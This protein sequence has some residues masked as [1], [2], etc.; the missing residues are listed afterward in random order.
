MPS[1]REIL[2]AKKAAVVHEQN[3]AA[4][5][6]K[7]PSPA[8]T[9]GAPVIRPTL[10]SLGI[11]RTPPAAPAPEARMLGNATP[12]EDVPFEFASEKNS[13]AAKIWLQ[14][15]QMEESQ[16]GVWMEPA[17]GEHAWLA[18]ESPAEPGKPILLFRLPLLNKHEAMQPF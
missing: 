12:G 18:V 17:P 13:E 7:S 1:L 2:A 3:G 5:V 9:G 6:G 10:E 16:L 4:G 11:T 15:R 14:A 8:V